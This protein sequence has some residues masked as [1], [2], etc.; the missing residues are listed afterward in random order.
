MEKYKFYNGRDRLGRRDTETTTGS[1]GKKRARV[2][3]MRRYNCVTL[4]AA[5]VVV[6]AV[7]AVVVVLGARGTC[8]ALTTERKKTHV[9]VTDYTCNV[10]L[11][12][13]IRV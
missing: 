7:V 12:L 10:L 2:R 13:N 11:L 4:Y 3:S 1:C 5:V 8:D 6:V 9:I